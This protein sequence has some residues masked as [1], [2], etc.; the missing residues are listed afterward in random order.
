[1][2]GFKA[3]ALLASLA[4]ASRSVLGDTLLDNELESIQNEQDKRQLQVVD[5]ME[6]IDVAEDLTDVE[7][8]ER[9]LKASKG[10]GK[11]GK[12]KGG[13]LKAKKSKAPKGKGKGK[14]GSKGLKAS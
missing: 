12:G 5:Q 14:G 4:Y 6:L 2:V 3:L 11:G 13:S 10:K 7:P 9:L 1:M 8:E